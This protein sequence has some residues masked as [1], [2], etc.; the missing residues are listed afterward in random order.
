MIAAVTL[1]AGVVQSATGFGF[2][3]ISV[4][5]FLLALDSLSA[6]QVNIVL[7]LFN[8]LVVAPCIWRLAP[9]GLMRGLVG[10]TLLGLPIGILAYREADL[11]QVKLVV[12]VLVVGFAM[13]L[14]LSPRRHS[15]SGRLMRA[16][17]IWT[18]GG[19]SGVLS[20]S[21][22][23]PG[24][25]VLLY[26]SHFAVDK[27]SFRATTLCLYVVSY[28]FALA[29]Q[30]TLGGMN[31]ATWTLSFILIPLAAIGGVVGHRLSPHLS[32]PVFRATVLATLLS[33][34]LYMLY[35]GFQAA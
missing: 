5:F 15:P 31:A 20:S 16:R 33:T 1:L 11:E 30:E 23:M 9:R 32:Q 21:L 22:A 26:L 25:P 12:A 34:G 13:H 28:G 4:P 24:P 19:L 2:A 3:L 14:I 10:G 6:I 35:A 27:D 8:A 7:N 29:L 17:S 18:I